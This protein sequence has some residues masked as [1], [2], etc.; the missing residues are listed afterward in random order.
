MVLFVPWSTPEFWRQSKTKRKPAIRLK[1]SPCVLINAHLHENGPLW[2]NSCRWV[3]GPCVTFWPEGRPQ[4]TAQ[5]CTP[6]E[7]NLACQAECRL[8]DGA[9]HRKCVSLQ[10]TFKA[11]PAGVRAGIS[12]GWEDRISRQTKRWQVP[13]SCSDRPGK[14]SECTSGT[15][16][17]RPK[18]AL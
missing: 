4:H 10:T 18:H 3:W 2:L 5:R 17:L 1:Q 7:G 6:R 14:K 16:N 9:A 8:L 15:G 12:V 11:P 13:D